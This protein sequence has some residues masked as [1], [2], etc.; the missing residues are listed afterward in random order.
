MDEEPEII[1]ELWQHRLNFLIFGGREVRGLEQPFAKLLH[2][3]TF[4]H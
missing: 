4:I 3:L 2:G 1:Q